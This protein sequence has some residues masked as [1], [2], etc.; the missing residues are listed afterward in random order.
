MTGVTMLRACLECKEKLTVKPGQAVK[1]YV[2]LPS[3]GKYRVT[4]DVDE[5][6]VAGKEVVVSKPGEK[7]VLSFKAPSKPGTYQVLV[8]AEKIVTP[9]PT[10]KPKPKPKPVE[11]EVVVTRPKPNILLTIAT[12]VVT[13]VL[14]G[15]ILWALRGEKK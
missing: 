7:V 13:G 4:V 12:G 14:T 2:W 10:P 15:L 5:K 1:T 8:K 3:P 6:R 9:A 11:K